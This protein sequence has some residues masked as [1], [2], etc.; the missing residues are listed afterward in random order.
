MFDIFKL[1]ILWFIS[2][3][4]LKSEFSKVFAFIPYP[5]DPNNRTFFPLQLFFV[6]SFDAET[7]NALT[8]KSFPF[9][10]FNAEFKFET[11]N[12]LICSVPPLALI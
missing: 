5:S 6:K 7:S 4:N 3:L 10:N 12:I 1:S 8:Q 9:K 2:T 11:L